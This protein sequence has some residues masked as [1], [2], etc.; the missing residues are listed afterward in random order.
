[1]HGGVH[2]SFFYEFVVGALLGNSVLGEDD[3]AV[4]ISDR[5]EPVGDCERGATFG[6]LSK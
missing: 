5:R 6:E 1:M 2:A 3:Y 4:G